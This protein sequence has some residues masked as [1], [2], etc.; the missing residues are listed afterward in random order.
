L[1]VE[2]P[3]RFASHDSADSADLLVATEIV[4]PCFRP[5]LG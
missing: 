3:R 1:W 5:N 2:I 4:P